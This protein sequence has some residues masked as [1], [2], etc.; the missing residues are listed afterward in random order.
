MSALPVLG[1]QEE[2]T[3]LAGSL[4]PPVPGAEC[5]DRLVE[6]RVRERPDAIAVR[7]DELALSY[8][9]LDRRAERVAARLRALGAGPGSLVATRLPRGADLVTAQ[10]GILKSGAA[11]L[12]LDPANPPGRLA[13]VLAEARPLL[14]LTDPKNAAIPGLGQLLTLDAVLAGP[15]HPEPRSAAGQPDR[16]QPT[17]LA[18]VIYTSGSTGVPKGVMIEHRALGNLVAWHHR[19]FGLGPDDRTALIAAP[20]FDASVW[21][22]W[23]ALAAGA[24]L[25]IPDA[26]TVLS[27]WELTDW[28][29]DRKVTCCFVP[30]PLVERMA[31]VSW[32][33]SGAR[34]ARAD[35]RRPAARH[36]PPGTALPASQQLR[37]DRGHGRGDLGTV[38]AAPH[39]REALP[40]I[41]R[42]IPGTEAYVLDE[43]LRPVP[44]G[45]SGELYLG[46]VALARGY[47]GRP[48]LTADRFV[49]HPFS[50]TPGARLY[51]TGDLVRRRSD[52][53]FDFLG[54]NDHQLKVRG[55][56]IEAGEIENVL[57]AHPGVRD[58]IVGVV[59]T[60]AG[61]SELDLTAYLVLADPAAPP[62]R[63]QL[64]EHVGR[65]LPAY[66]RPHDYQVLASLPLTSNGKVDRAALAGQAV[67]LAAPVAATAG[68][69]AQR[70][71]LEQEISG[72][73]AKALGHD[74]FGSHDNFFD[75]GGH[76]LLLATVRDILGRESGREVSVLTLFEYPTVAALARHLEAAETPPGQDVPTPAR[77]EAADPADPADDPAAARLR[78]GNARL[79]AMRAQNRRT[80]PTPVGR[81]DT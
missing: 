65:R 26:G 24:T 43:R 61:G 73:W 79:R 25:E 39:G 6:R 18:Y 1:A 4:E 55:F 77:G 21:E 13:A 33:A 78:R 15:E 38:T 35:R 74:R 57:R 81:T 30:T 80:N 12:P 2:R 69:D 68:A 20:G 47:L 44:V 60:A 58:A 34:R 52:G 11:Y 41:G 72:V 8:A 51:R 49:P 7:T 42:P 45:M 50:R 71:P 9:E 67:P 14:T 28:L 29:V 53:T 19:E 17:D 40:D 3:V 37:A 46:G 32:P 10:F 75:I 16:A 70:T 48:E 59:P 63:A 31:E 23:P 54:R 66:M 5:V 36:R 64:H 22:I 62:D 56:R 27:P 76:S